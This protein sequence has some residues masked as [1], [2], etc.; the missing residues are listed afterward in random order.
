MGLESI[1]TLAHLLG[2]AQYQKQV[3]D[4]LD[5][6]QRLRKDRTGHVT[7]AALKM[8]AIWQLPNGPLKE[9]RDRIFRCETPTAGYPN[10]LADPFLQIWLW[11]YD[12]PQAAD[13]AWERHLH[14]PS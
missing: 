14:S 10:L 8:G 1:S 12:A 9:E 11:G 3:K 4:C 5:V 7:R 13:V 2:K 6:Y